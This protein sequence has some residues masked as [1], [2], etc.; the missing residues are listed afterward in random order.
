M[1]QVGCVAKLKCSS[2]VQTGGLEIQV[3]FLVS[4]KPLFL[5]SPTFLKNEDYRFIKL[6]LNNVTHLDYY[7][8]L[9]G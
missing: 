9:S 3:V 8:P 1:T 6:Y 2:E 4:P 7:F 5:F